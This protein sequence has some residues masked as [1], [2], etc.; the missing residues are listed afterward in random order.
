[1]FHLFPQLP[2]PFS[3]KIMRFNGCRSAAEKTVPAIR[4]S[5]AAIFLVL[6]FLQGSLQ[7]QVDILTPRSVEGQ[8]ILDAE[9]YSPKP[10]DT[11][12]AVSV[13]AFGSCNKLSLP[14]NMWD[15]VTANDPNLWLWLGDIIY[16]DT[17]DMRALA[18][19]YRQLKTNPGYKSLRKKSQVIGIYDDHDYGINDGGKGFPMKRGAQKALLDFLDVPRQAPVRRQEGAYQ[20]YTF[21]KGDQQIK[22]IILDTRY[23]RDTLI[24]DPTKQRRYLP[25]ME[26]DMLGEAQWQWLENELANSTASLNILC[27]SVQVI[28]DEHPHEKWGNFPNSRK[29]LFSTIARIKPNN[30]LILSGDRH[31]AEVSKMDIQGL[32]YP[33]YD[34]TS[35]GLTHIRAG[36]AEPNKYRVGDLIVKR[37]FGLLKVHWENSRPVVHMEVRGLQNELFQEL[38]VRY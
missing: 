15:Y 13:I 14:Q 22:I 10:I 37:N 21:G 24:P 8:E 25:N 18:A 36:T 16:A 17:S 11:D 31:M 34:F 12:Q 5:L 4:L 38:I 28:S 29:R 23:N 7:A 20:A 30:L 2:D 6:I 1:M 27:T 26:G 32:P 35:S 33:L 19:E 9:A 3:M